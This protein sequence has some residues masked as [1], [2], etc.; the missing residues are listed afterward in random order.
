[1][2]NLKNP[3]K[4]HL[5]SQTILKLL[6]SLSSINF[7]LSVECLIIT[8]VLA[9][10]KKF[11]TVSFDSKFMK[12]LTFTKEMPTTQFR[13]HTVMR[14]PKFDIDVNIPIK[15]PM[16][17]AY[18]QEEK[19]GKPL[20]QSLFFSTDVDDDSYKKDAKYPP[21]HHNYKNL[22]YSSSQ[23]NEQSGPA[24]EQPVRPETHNDE[25]SVRKPFKLPFS[26]NFRPEYVDGKQESDQSRQ[27]SGVTRRNAPINYQTQS[28]DNQFRRSAQQMQEQASSSY[29]TINNQY[30]DEGQ[31]N[32]P[33]FVPGGFVNLQLK[34]PEGGPKMTHADVDR[35]K[36]AEQLSNTPDAMPIPI[37]NYPQL[38]NFYGG[39]GTFTN[40]LDDKYV[41]EDS[42][43]SKIKSSLLGLTSKLHHGRKST[44]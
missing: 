39:L 24:D 43:L 3:C 21:K 9:G 27:D 17:D 4:A 12:P 37:L 11:K 34:G 38:Q 16:E 44:A 40:G 20:E 29:Q 19:P 36:W 5:L 2:K 30:K 41:F 25:Q 6:V 1:M 42:V 31:Y 7:L 13:R 22:E 32:Q 26:F 18:P 33:E 10:D 15:L 35:K 23:I 14:P 28:L 8:S